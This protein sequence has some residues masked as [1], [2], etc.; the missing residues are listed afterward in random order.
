MI[1]FL[2]V[3]RLPVTAAMK[4]IG[5]A[6]ADGLDPAAE[7]P[8]RSVDW[9][10]AGQLLVMPALHGRYAGVK[11]ASVAEHA[12]PRIKGVY[13]LWDADTLAP[14][15]LMDGAALTLLRTPAVSAL[16]AKHLARPDSR[17]LVVFGTGPQA[18]A[19]E[20]A[21]RAELPIE[22]VDVVGR[23]GDPSAVVRDADVVCCCTTARDPVF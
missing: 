22:H 3:A 19:H 21:L 6:L 23:G 5:S 7:S 15:A 13:V 4:A 20:Q 14:I 2:D 10:P 18:R 16:A 9:S 11:L 17:R 1:A 8:R 12:L